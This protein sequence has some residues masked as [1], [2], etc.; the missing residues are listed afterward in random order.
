MWLIRVATRVVDTCPVKRLREVVGAL[1]EGL[2]VWV[3]VQYQLSSAHGGG[4]CVR[5]GWI[6]SLLSSTIAVKEDSASDAT[7]TLQD[8][9]PFITRTKRNYSRRQKSHAAV[10]YVVGSGSA[11]QPATCQ[12]SYRS[13]ERGYHCCGIN[14]RAEGWEVAEG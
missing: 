1:Q 14:A 6:P 3:A 4:V 7:E 11:P 5:C 10:R 2:C 8:S 13:H 9:N 12:V